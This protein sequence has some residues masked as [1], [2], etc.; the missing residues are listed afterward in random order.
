MRKKYTKWYMNNEDKVRNS[1]ILRIVHYWLF[2]PS[3]YLYEL[4]KEILD[5]TS[6]TF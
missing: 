5:N 6:P 4:A 2:S 3:I 1:F